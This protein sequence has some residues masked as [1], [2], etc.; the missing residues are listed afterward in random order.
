ME[1][2]IEGLLNLQNNLPLLS[3]YDR[4]AIA[5]LGTEFEIDFVQL[6]FTRTR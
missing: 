2:S 1:R 6:A 3:D 4:E 5:A